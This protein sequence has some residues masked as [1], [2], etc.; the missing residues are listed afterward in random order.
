MLK[1]TAATNYSSD[2]TLKLTR[3]SFNLPAGHNFTHKCFQ[4][5]NAMSEHM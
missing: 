4:T 1:W 2:F 3:S 5:T